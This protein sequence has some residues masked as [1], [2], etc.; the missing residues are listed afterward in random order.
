MVAFND[1]CFEKLKDNT[2]IPFKCASDHVW[3][4]LPSWK[5]EF[6]CMERGYVRAGGEILGEKRV[7]GEPV[8]VSQWL[9]TIRDK[10]GIE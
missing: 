2:F 1:A 7:E 6:A 10:W 5:D 4:Y 9:R 8:L 3:L